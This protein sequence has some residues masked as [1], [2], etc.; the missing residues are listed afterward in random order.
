LP[1]S[2]RFYVGGGNGFHLL[3]GLMSKRG[4][5]PPPPPP[6]ASTCSQASCQSEVF[7]PHLTGKANR[8]P[9]PTL[10]HPIAGGTRLNA[11]RWERMTRGTT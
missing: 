11:A 8:N 7:I 9:A 10:C 5:V 3:S 4:C 6:S 2:R 1:P